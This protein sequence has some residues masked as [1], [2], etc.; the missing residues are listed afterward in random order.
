MEVWENLGLPAN[1]VA[2]IAEHSENTKRF[3]TRL[4]SR[5]VPRV[6]DIGLWGLRVGQV[7]RTYWV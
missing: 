5:I 4:F 6:K 3:R 1:E 2:E 7:L